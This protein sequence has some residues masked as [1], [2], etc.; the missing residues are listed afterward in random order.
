MSHSDPQVRALNPDI[1]DAVTRIE[2]L[3]S[4][5]SRT[6]IP[7]AEATRLLNAVVRLYAA[8]EANA[9]NSAAESAT[10]EGIAPVALDSLALS[11]TEVV[12]VISALMHAEQLNT[13][14]LALWQSAIGRR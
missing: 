11:T 13:F 14:D 2:G 3:V 7:V 10:T 5:L 12:T 1:V 8:A 9:N 4:D 6:K